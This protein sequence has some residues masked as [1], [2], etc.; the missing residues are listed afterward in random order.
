MLFF[1]ALVMRSIL[2]LFTSG[3]SKRSSNDWARLANIKISGP[4][5]SASPRY[6]RALLSSAF[7]NDSSIIES[8]LPYFSIRFGSEFTQFVNSFSIAC[9]LS[10][11]FKLVNPLFCPILYL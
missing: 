5:K 6:D 2:S 4:R 1:M 3:F 9:F 7:L 10:I 11:T 8:D